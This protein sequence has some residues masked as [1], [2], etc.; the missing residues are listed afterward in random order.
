MAKIL[1]PANLAPSKDLRSS[2]ILQILVVRDNVD[3]KAS[4]FEIMSP[5]RKG[6]EDGQQF[7]VMR[8]VVE[9]GRLQ[10]PGPKRNRVN[11]AVVAGDGKNG[12]DGIVRSISFEGNLTVRNPVMEDRSFR[13]GSLESVESVLTV[14]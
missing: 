12:G 13:K 14:V 1:G 6:V 7:L 10:R 9:F 3:R 5:M 8:V 2:E 4:T 11:L